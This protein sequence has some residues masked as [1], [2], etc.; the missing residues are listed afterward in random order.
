[1]NKTKIGFHDAFAKFE[2][3]EGSVLVIQLSFR[4]VFVNFQT[5]LGD[6]FSKI[7]LDMHCVLLTNIATF[8][9]RSYQN[10]TISGVQTLS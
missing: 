2:T 3:V 6:T 10:I 7:T 8:I 4:D 5:I 9:I 1:M